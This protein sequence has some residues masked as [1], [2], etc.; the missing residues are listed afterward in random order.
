MSSPILS[1][2]WASADVAANAA[3]TMAQNAR[4]AFGMEVLPWLEHPPIVGRAT[5]ADL[6]LVAISLGPAP[7]PSSRVTRGAPP[8]G[9]A[10]APLPPP[11]RPRAP[12]GPAEP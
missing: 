8:H 3:A 7:A 9:W 11:V 10:P 2:C 6:F 4:F 1:G 12:P 5:S